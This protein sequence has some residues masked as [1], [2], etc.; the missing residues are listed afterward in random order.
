LAKILIVED[1]IKISRVLELELSHEGFSVT[2]AKD[3]LSAV[4]TFKRFKPDVVLLDIM[5]PRIDGFEVAKRLKEIDRKV[6]IIML[7]AKGQL[8]DKLEGFYSGAD[9]YVVKP[10]DIEELLA[11]IDALL[12]RIK[13]SQPLEEKLKFESIIIDPNSRRVYVEGEEIELSKTEFDLLYFL[14]KNHDVVL[15]KSRILEEVWGVDYYTDNVV[16]VYINYLRKKL[17][18]ASKLIKTVRGVGYIFRGDVT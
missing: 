18:N 3:G 6:G 16:E 1:D 15:S 17:K 5:L 12:R 13:T 4:E 10:F 9:D 14:A 7:T 11:R 2:V 8:D